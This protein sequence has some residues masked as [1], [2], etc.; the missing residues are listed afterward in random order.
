MFTTVVPADSRT[1]VSVPGGG[2]D[3]LPAVTTGPALN[4]DRPAVTSTEQA[5][6]DEPQVL[7]Q[8]RALVGLPRMMMAACIVLL[9][10]N[11]D[12]YE[13][14]YYY[15]YYNYYNYFYKEPKIFEQPKYV[16]FEAVGVLHS[17]AFCILVTAFLLLCWRSFLPVR[18]LTSL[19][20]CLN[21]GIVIGGFIGGKFA[22]S[23]VYDVS[24][25]WWQNMIL[26]P[27]P[28]LFTGSTNPPSSM[29]GL[30]IYARSD[31]PLCDVISGVHR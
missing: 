30:S 5:F 8:T 16:D 12:L 17:R 25:K 13:G 19:D 24:S 15:Y 26:H 3:E 4:Q 28:F 14:R 22:T 18:K 1:S 2:D 6:N 31:L 27:H 23:H 20:I 10:I 11:S 9:T 7:N 29:S 21:A